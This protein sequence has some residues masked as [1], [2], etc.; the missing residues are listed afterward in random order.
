M[1]TPP[2]M[3]AI[4]Y[5]NGV[6]TDDVRRN[7]RRASCNATDTV[8]VTII[9]TDEAGFDIIYRNKTI[10]VLVNNYKYSCVALY[11]GVYLFISNLDPPEANCNSKCRLTLIILY[12]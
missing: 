3:D 10:G 6:K 1:C 5:C 11:S 7:Q 2:I 8:N 9:L 4:V 12:T